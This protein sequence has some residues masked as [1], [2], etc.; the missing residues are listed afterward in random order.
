VTRFDSVAVRAEFGDA[1]AAAGF[2][3]KAP[4]ILD[5]Q[6]RRAAVAGDRGS[7]RSGRYRGF[8]DGFRPAGFVQNFRDET[9]TGS[10]KFGAASTASLTAAER[11]AMQHAAAEAKARRD[12]EEADAQAAV[13]ARAA[14]DWA[15]AAPATSA[16]PY[17]HHKAI[18]PHNLRVGASGE[19]LV[20]MHDFTGQLSGLQ[21]IAPTPDGSKR[22]AKGARVIG[23]HL[24]LGKPV[25]GGVLL[26]AEGYATGASLYEAAGHPVAVAFIKDNFVAIARAYMERH[27][28]LRVAFCGDNDHHLPRR[29]PPRANV[30]KVAAE[31][32][33]CE[34][35][36]T[37][38]LPSFESH[39]SFTDWNDYAALHGFAA[40]RAA[41][42]AAL[43]PRAWSVSE[44]RAALVDH[45]DAFMARTLDWHAT[46]DT[47][48]QPE[49]AGLAVE[50]GAG[51]TRAACEALPGFISEARAR[52]LPHR[53]LFTVAT[54][55]L[56]DEVSTRLAD[57]GLNHATWRGR[58]AENPAT[59]RPMCDDLPAVKDALI[60]GEEVE[61]AVC[62]KPD[63]PRCK[64]F[65]VCQYQRQKA[66]AAAAD[67]VVAAHE[68]MLGRLLQAVGKVFA[69]TIADEGWLQDGAETRVLTAETLRAGEVEHPVPR[70]DNPTQRDDLATNDLHVFRRKLADALDQVPDG[71][72][73]RT[74]LAAAGL[75]PDDCHNA[76][77][78]EWRRKI[79]G[80]I[81]P[82]MTADARREAVRRCAGN[83]AIPRLGALWKAAA[84]LLDDDDEAS[85]RVELGR[86]DT[87]EGS[88]R[89]ILLNTLRPIAKRV[90]TAPMLL[91]DATLPS[92]LLHH[93]L[94]RLTVLAEIKAA[95]PHMRVHRIRGGFGKTSITPHPKAG[96]DQQRRLNRID[97]LRDYIMLHTD[98]APALVVTYKDLEPHFADLPGV[99]T[100]HFG[101]TSGR[102]EWRD[103]RHLFIIGRPMASPEDT[104]RLAAAL[105]GR[106]VPAEMPGLVTATA[107]MRDGSQAAIEVRRYLDPDLEAVR[108]SITDSELVQVIGRGRGINRTEETPL[109]VYVLAGDVVLP[110]PLDSLSDWRDVAPG[111]FER[112]AAR[113][114]IL[115]SPCDATR[116][117]PDL[118]PTAEAAKKALQRAKGGRDFGDIPLWRV[119]IGECPRNTPWLRV[120]YRPAGRGQQIRI[121]WVRPDRLT[122]LRGWLETIT[123]AKLTLYSLPAV[124][125][126]PV[127]QAAAPIP[128]P[129]PPPSRSPPART[130]AT[131]PLH[132][133]P[134]RNAL[135]HLSDRLEAMRLQ[136]EAPPAWVTSWPQQHSHEGARR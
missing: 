71:Y 62:G 55:K 5:G 73:T 50:V 104:R 74:A 115:T 136:P 131:T 37:A 32:A 51:K 87:A 26:I 2:V 111:P 59:G 98:G 127:Q 7:Q 121:A 79:T 43:P 108:A 100:A 45:V 132:L 29:D 101:A 103:V 135:Q 77:K 44:A 118:F 9:R 128:A 64:F 72:L 83:A 120:E 134:H 14:R 93:R 58:A 112:M 86:H 10:W 96:K 133:Q 94:P 69:L 125:D 129:A 31:T 76:N 47:T 52:Q 39:H 25:P 82:G 113:G 42:E 81:H 30:G 78:L 116:G 20:P 84:A 23:L 13:A 33:A 18:E 54:H 49:H 75:A 90:A 105:T 80:V 122:E 109:D 35:G 130:S 60:V 91:L 92:V 24:L 61:S 17:L 95:A 22:F 114:V 107:T 16:H 68:I 123:G 15:A 124:A 88:Q 11:A 6:W 34:A 46:S 53:V 57:L 36:G 41:I 40:V 48:R 63:G 56:G 117:Y 4:A 110:L 106:P 66:T 89:V 67:V 99:Q 1:L 27:P 97:E 65:D 85:G 38:I 19:L 3:L 8:L 126:P 102:D 21:R 70:H 28:G 119:P 12:L